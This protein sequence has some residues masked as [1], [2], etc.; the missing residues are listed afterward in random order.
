MHLPY[1]STAILQVATAVALA[2]SL[3]AGTVLVPSHVYAAGPYVVNSIGDDHDQFRGD[4]ISA[5]AGGVCTLRG[6][7]EE[8]NTHSGP[9]SISFNIPGPRVQTIQISSP[10]TVAG[11]NLTIDGYTQPGAIPNTAPLT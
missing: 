4:G 9:Q 11:G 3:S 2:A 5:T 7:I 6:A 1:S 10:L 8:A